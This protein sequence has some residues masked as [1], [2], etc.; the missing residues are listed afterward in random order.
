MRFW[1]ASVALGCGLI[2]AALALRTRAEAGM[3]GGV[4][5]RTLPALALVDGQWAAKRAHRLA[6]RGPPL[7]PTATDL[8]SLPLTAEGPIY[9]LPVAGHLQHEDVDPDSGEERA[10][11]LLA[12][13]QGAAM[14]APGAGRVAYAGPFRTYGRVLILDHGL[15][16]TTVL[17]GIQSLTVTQGSDLAGGD[18]IGRSGDAV[19]VLL[20]HHGRNVDLP[21]LFRAAGAR[22]A[23]VI[24]PQGGLR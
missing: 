18:P 12:T 16:W 15:G 8:G 14:I 21:G 9:R 22:P 5:A 11:V 20:L 7:V 13:Q 23:L 17:T 1:V 4:F 3:R 10:G 24:S 2:T 19:R 6:M